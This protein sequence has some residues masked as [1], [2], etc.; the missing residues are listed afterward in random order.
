LEKIEESGMNQGT[1]ISILSILIA[2]GACMAAKKDQL[3]EYKQRRNLK[4]SP[5]PKGKVSKSK[6]KAKVPIFVIQKHDASHEHYD[7]RIEI[8]GVLKSWAVP[9][10]PSFDPKIKRLAV[11][12]DDHPMEYADFE[13]VIPKGNYG[14]GTVMVWD[15]G[16]YENLKLDS[17]DDCYNHGRIEILLKGKKLKGTF[18]LVRTLLHNSKDWLLIKLRDEYASAEKNPVSTQKKSALTGRTM[19]QIAASESKKK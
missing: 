14:A 8:D 2:G 3:K 12:T 9:K 6:K 11:P 19:A 15:M 18:A 7:L 16:T 13:G 5:E 4:K 10:G 1:I 17:M